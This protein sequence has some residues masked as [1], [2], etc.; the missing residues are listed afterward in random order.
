MAY[1][2]PALAMGGA[3]VEREYLRFVTDPDLVHATIAAARAA[4]AG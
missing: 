1:R 2:N 3:A 4:V